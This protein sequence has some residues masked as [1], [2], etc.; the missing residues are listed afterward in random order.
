MTSDKA[1]RKMPKGS[2]EPI[3]VAKIIANPQNPRGPDVA[4]SDDSLEYLKSSI[5]EYGLLVPLVVLRQGDRY[6]LVDGERR[7]HAL[8]ALREKTALAHILTGQNDPDLL[9]STMFHIHMNRKDWDAKQQCRA[10]EPLYDELVSRLGDEDQEQLADRLSKIT[11]TPRRTAKNRTQFLRWPKA[12]KEEVYAATERDPYWYVVEIE[13]GIVEPAQ[14]NF[15]EYFSRVPVDDVRTFLY[16]KYADKYVAAGTEVRQALLVVK[17]HHDEHERTVALRI[18]DQLVS[19][20]EYTFQ[21]AHEDFVAQ[22]PH[23][24]DKPAMGPR[25]LLN[26]INDIASVLAE[27][28]PAYFHGQ[29]RAVPDESELSEA[30]DR[31]KRA[32]ISCENRLAG[33][34]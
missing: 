25:A 32:L 7:L 23:Y 17:P 11:G 30:L 10:L 12:I 9:R 2:L 33:T 4:E 1:M 15:P 21:Q 29:G 16:R 19:V 28:D 24:A 6:L 18:L 8:R 26:R 5:R 22:L 27:F 3:E 20:P 31:L 14:R 13:R 34:E